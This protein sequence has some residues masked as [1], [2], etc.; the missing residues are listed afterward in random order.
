MLASDQ[1]LVFLLD[2]ARDI[3]RKMAAA[4]YSEDETRAAW[5]YC[6]Q[7]GITEATGLGADRLTEAGKARARA[8]AHK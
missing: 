5:N 3:A 1:L 7:A 2:G 6:R 8:L 4:G